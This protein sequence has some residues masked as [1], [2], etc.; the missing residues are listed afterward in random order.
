[1]A[2][3]NLTTVLG[4]DGKVTAAKHVEHTAIRTAAVGNKYKVM[5]LL[6]NTGHNYTGTNFT[7]HIQLN[8][9][10]TSKVSHFSTF[11]YIYQIFITLYKPKI[12]LKEK[13]G[14]TKQLI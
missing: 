5:V 1:M 3:L 9:N 4:A 6:L 14:Q 2:Y 10:V 12:D 8:V 13:K 7:L 11:D